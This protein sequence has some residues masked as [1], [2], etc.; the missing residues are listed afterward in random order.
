MPAIF[1]SVLLL[2]RILDIGFEYAEG[3]G[4]IA[5]VGAL[6]LVRAQER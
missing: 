6:Y 2:Y 5:D 4:A 3:G 1:A